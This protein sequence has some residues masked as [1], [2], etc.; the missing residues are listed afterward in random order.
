MF[1]WI[2]PT[3]YA[4][5]LNGYRSKLGSSSISNNKVRVA[6]NRIQDGPMDPSPKRGHSEREAVWAQVLRTEPHC[7]G[8][9]EAYMHGNGL[10]PGIQCVGGGYRERIPGIARASRGIELICR[11]LVAL[12]EP[13][14]NPSFGFRF[15][16]C[17][18]WNCFESSHIDDL[19]V[20]SAVVFR[21]SSTWIHL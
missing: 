12:C 14:A 3:R 20:P 7:G 19:S 1:N 13:P 18:Y 6:D 15:P 2:I 4:V 5:D 8:V 16:L 11:S 10:H 9:D 17:N 21:I